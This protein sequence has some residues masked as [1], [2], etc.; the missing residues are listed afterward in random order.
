[1]PLTK[2]RNHVGGFLFNLVSRN[3]LDENRELKEEREKT[4]VKPN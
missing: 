3:L 4:E 1:M 2:G